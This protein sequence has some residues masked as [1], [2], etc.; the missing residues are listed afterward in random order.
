MTM[1]NSNEIQSISRAFKNALKELHLLNAEMV[2][3]SNEGHF[4]RSSAEQ[5]A[6]EI[7]D[8]LT[9][10]KSVADHVRDISARG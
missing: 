5:L 8:Q 1:T 3:A 2:S 7:D 9:E 4:T 10:L 6:N